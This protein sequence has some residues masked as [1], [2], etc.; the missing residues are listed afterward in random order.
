MTFKFYDAV[1]DGSMNIKDA[2]EKTKK[3]HEDILN[4]LFH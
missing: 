2:V 4:T 3:A 1:K